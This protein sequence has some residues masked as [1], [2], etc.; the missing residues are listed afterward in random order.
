MFDDDID[1]DE[2]AFVVGGEGG[3][4][5]EDYHETDDLY[6][7]DAFVDDAE[8]NDTISDDEIDVVIEASEAEGTFG[9]ANTFDVDVLTQNLQNFSKHATA[10][11]VGRKI[12]TR[13][14]ATQTIAKNEQIVKLLRKALV[15]AKDNGETEDEINIQSQ[16]DACNKEI[17]AGRQTLNEMGDPKNDTADVVDLTRAIPQGA[18]TSQ[19]NSQA[20]A[21]FKAD[22]PELFSDKAALGHIMAIDNE[23]RSDENAPRAGS[24]KYIDELA[25][26]VAKATRGKFVIKA[27]S[28]T[29]RVSGAPTSQKGNTMSGQRGKSQKKSSGPNKKVQLTKADRNKMIRWGLDPN[30]KVVQQVWANNKRNMAQDSRFRDYV[31]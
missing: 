2:E 9:D 27:P 22:N 4:L 23:M 16:I 21:K 31:S 26:R 24:E 17:E 5:E 8:N 7:D 28:G 30:D 10:D 18:H 6:A 13:A 3:D 19:P 15:E 12:V 11:H 20:A 14:L 25:R 29:V 1:D